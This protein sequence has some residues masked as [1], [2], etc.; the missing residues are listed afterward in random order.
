MPEK[1]KT[2][3]VDIMQI[4]VINE[5]EKMKERNQWRKWRTIFEVMAVKIK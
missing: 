5:E 2:S 3:Y 1:K 4:Y